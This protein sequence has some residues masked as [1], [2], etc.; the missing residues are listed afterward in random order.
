ML[1]CSRTLTIASVSLSQKKIETL[2]D[3]EIM[4]SSFGP[5][6]LTAIPKLNKHISITRIKWNNDLII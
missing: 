4:Y 5:K 3:P 6:K 2:A 1:V